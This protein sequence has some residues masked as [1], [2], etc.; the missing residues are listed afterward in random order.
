MRYERIDRLTC[1]SCDYILVRALPAFYGR[2]CPHC[3]HLEFAGCDYC[4]S[5]RLQD[6]ICP[7]CKET[8]VDDSVC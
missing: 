3:S 4:V 1:P 6:E 8:C 5:E 2:K 7:L